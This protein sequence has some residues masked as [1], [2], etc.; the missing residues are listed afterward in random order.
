MS[1]ESVAGKGIQDIALGRS[2]REKT[3]G[4]IT[5]DNYI[6]LYHTKT[7]ISLQTFP[8]NINDNLS[9]NF[10]NYTPLTR[11]APIYSYISSGPRQMQ[12]D[13][14]L[15]RDMFG[16]IRTYDSNLNIVQNLNSLTNMNDDYIDTII[17]EIQ[18]AALPKYNSS[19]KMVDPPIVA[20]RFGDDIFCKGVVT[21]S[22]GVS[23]SGP[24]L[25]TNKY[26]CVDISFQISEIDPYDADTIM[27]FGGF[28]G[29]STDLERNVFKNTNSGG[30]V[31]GATKRAPSRPTRQFTTNQRY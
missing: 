17:R 20:I 5:I 13:L 11:T 10:S 15:H 29:F 7:L 24:I 19:E 27:Q 16:E 18:A 6:Y 9:V 28:R 4:F 12:I 31:G 14:K 3:V 26:A 8:A 22:V 2:G 23:Y 1:L 25:E 30:S 21:S